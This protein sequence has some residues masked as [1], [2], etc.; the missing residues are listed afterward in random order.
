MRAAV[1]FIRRAAETGDCMDPNMVH[2][3]AGALKMLSETAATWK[4]LD[5]RLEQHDS[6]MARQLAAAS[7]P[8]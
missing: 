8:N 5:K 7:L 1:G 4:L 6:D 3:I 2:S